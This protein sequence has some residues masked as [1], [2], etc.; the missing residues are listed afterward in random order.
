ML[1]RNK[2]V[3]NSKSSMASHESEIFRIDS[4]EESVNVNQAQDLEINSQRDASTDKE[5]GKEVRGVETGVV[6]T[7]DIVQIL[8]L[9]MEGMQSS[10]EKYLDKMEEIQSSLSGSIRVSKEEMQINMKEEF[11]NIRLGNQGNIERLENY[12]MGLEERV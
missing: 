7:P 11:R 6:I 4:Q 12:V 1:L 9:N 3:T 8:L 5:L 10:L 2:K